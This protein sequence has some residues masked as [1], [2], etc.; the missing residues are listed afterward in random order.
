MIR[1][2]QF[3]GGDEG[4]ATVDDTGNV[5]VYPGNENVK[6][7]LIVADINNSGVVFVRL[8]PLLPAE[9]DKGIPLYPGGFVE[10]SEYMGLYNGI[11][12]GI[13]ATGKTGKLFWHDGR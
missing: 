9:W 5:V 10:L 1:A 7:L 2:C 8:D 13:A 12:R 11:V 3:G 6:W 4:N